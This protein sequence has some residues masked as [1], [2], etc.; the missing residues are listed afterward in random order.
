MKT[1]HEDPI[2]IVFEG[3][4]GSG[5]STCA[6]GTAEAL[7]AELLTTPSEPIRQV[8]SQIISEFQGSQ[9]ARQVFYI[10]TVLAASGRIRRLLDQGRSVVL[11]RYFLSTQAYASFRGTNLDLDFIGATLVPADLTVFLH[12]PLDIRIQRIEQRGASAADRETMSPQADA[13]LRQEHLRRSEADYIGEW[14]SMDSSESTP[15]ELAG[16]VLEAVKQPNFM[17]TANSAS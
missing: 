9:E 11:D 4:D 8:R 5:K 10:S 13:M 3:L 12:A 1:L 16:R 15:A 7:D 17:K 14:L 6:R 2:F